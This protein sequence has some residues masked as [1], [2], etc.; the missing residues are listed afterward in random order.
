MRGSSGWWF[1]LGGGQDEVRKCVIDCTTDRGQTWITLNVLATVKTLR[2]A[3]FAGVPFLR[4][5]FAIQRNEHYGCD[6]PTASSWA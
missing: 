4:K 6:T 3:R 2:E 1:R 5:S